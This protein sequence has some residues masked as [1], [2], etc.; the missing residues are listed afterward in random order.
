M[1]ESLTGPLAALV[2]PMDPSG[3]LDLDALAVHVGFQR[4]HGVS[5]I[6]VGGSIGEAA[7][8]TL[9]ERRGLTT[10]AVSA[11]A[12]SVEVIVSVTHDHVDSSLALMDHAAA[13]G[14]DGLL[15]SVPPFYRLTPDEQL[16][17]WERVA[18]HTSLPIVA[19][20]SGH[21]ASPRPSVDELEA[22][23][24]LD[25]VIA[26]KE[27][28]PDVTRLQTLVDRF[29]PDV[30][31]IAA[32][33]KTLPEGAATGAAAAMTASIC[34]APGR[35]R[36][37]IE[38]AQAGDIEGAR[39]AFGPIEGFRAAF[40]AAMDAGYP[41][42]IPYTKAAC[43]LVGLPAGPPRAPLAPV[44]EPERERIRDAVLAAR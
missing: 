36:T 22:V 8:L 19:Y 12:G 6:V 26:V 20:C 7:S 4:D 13:E 39:E 43:D 16:R 27:A 5:A 38:R 1:H 32:G 21:G 18:A 44:D 29:Q 24:A 23:V 3:G 31:V 37:V 40:Q 11:A 10:A 9:D 41:S 25:P 28:S 35:V 30:P 33:E 15:V 2:T 17:F 42:Y 14:A 34:F